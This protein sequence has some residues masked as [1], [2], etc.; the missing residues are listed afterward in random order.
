MT[1]KPQSTTTKK[2]SPTLADAIEG[3]F[4]SHEYNDVT[5]CVTVNVVDALMAIANAIHRLAAVQERD[6]EKRE[7]ARLVIEALN[8]ADPDRPGHA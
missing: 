3:A 7:Q 8:R 2:P 4:T 1:S 6:E 5:G